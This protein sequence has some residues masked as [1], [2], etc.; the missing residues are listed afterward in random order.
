MEILLTV[1]P[2]LAKYA[3]KNP[4]KYQGI[5]GIYSDPVGHKLGSGGGTVNVLLEHFRRTGSGKNY[6]GIGDL[7]KNSAA[8][9]RQKATSNQQIFSTW[10]SSGKRIIIHSD[11][12]SRRLPAYGMMGKSFIPFPVFRWGRGQRIDQTLFD[13]QRPLLEKI[14]E[15]APE[16]LNTLVAVGDA[17]VWTDQLRENIPQADVVCIGIWAHPEV[18]VK[19]GVF[20][21]PRNKPA[22]LDY[23]LQKPSLETLQSLTEHF[24]CLLDAGIWLLSDRA[25][26]AL[27]ERCGWMRDA[28]Y[29]MQN[30]G[31]WIKAYDLYSEFGSLLGARGDGKSSV[32]IV[33]MEGAEFYHFGSNADLLKS[34]SSLQNWV[35]DQREI[36]HKKIKPSPDIFVQN[37]RTSIQLDNRH[38]SIW[39]E[40]SDIS[41]GWRLINHHII[42]GVPENSWNLALPAGI[43][44]DFVPIGKQQW[45]IRNYGF[46]DPFR[47]ETSDESTMWMNKPIK[48]WFAERGFTEKELI[49]VCEGDIYDCRLFPV[50][51]EKEI[52]EE[53]LQWMISG[54]RD[55]KQRWLRGKRLSAGEIIKQAN[56]ERLGMMRDGWVGVSLER[57]AKNAKQSI[58]YQLDLKRVAEEFS[59]RKLELP[60]EM[61]DNGLRMTDQGLMKGI[62]DLMFRSAYYGIKK[63][64]RA[65]KY[66]DEAFALLK[67]GML[68]K[69]K[70]NKLRPVMSVKKD[71]ILWG[72]SP[73]RLDLAGG[74]TDTPPYCILYGGSVVNMAVELNGQPPIQVYIRPTGQ[75]GFR[76]HSIDLGLSETVR[77]Y[78][79]IDRLSKVGSAFAIPKAALKLAGFHPQYSSAVYKSLEEQLRDFGG[80]LD[81]SLMVAVPKGSGLGTSSVLAGTILA[82]LSDFCKLGWD[83]HETAFRTLL[84]EQILTTGGGWQDQVGGLFEGVK[85]IESASG[86]VQKPRIRWV[87]EHLFTRPETSQLIMLYYTGITRIAKHI[88]TDIVQGMFL[89]SD[90]LLGILSEMK[91]HARDTYGAIQNH[92]WDGLTTA[93]AHSWELN[94]RLDPGT[95]PPE[96]AAIS[97]VIKDHMASCKLL[98]AGGG[99]YLIIF[100]KD[101]RS[102]NNIKVLLNDSPPNPR[103]RFVDW[104]LSDSGLEITKS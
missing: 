87:P 99:G 24:L 65:G 66:R 74:W 51:D 54:E 83:K 69:I 40:N 62:H 79:D 98:G 82:G 102:A 23:M 14:L 38:S 78:E 68:E 56:L 95:N 89:N 1:P 39:I 55:F 103:A 3:K 49:R 44:L 76:I 15:K 8:R 17:L 72:R 104:N 97:D 81:I 60:G 20:V 57:L 35:M 70:G 33:P 91:T 45:C 71:Q 6:E 86:L 18:A 5:S 92:D 64:K 7:L 12:Q 88:L 67:E 25:V 2:N 85:L 28:V 84:L 41:E 26:L 32:A 93:I 90:T 48:N 47:G 52:N 31:F 61:I 43:C 29:E 100:A 77:S 53:L 9:N 42:T 21:C 10:L 80:G 59:L 22:T 30:E 58:F 94:Q 50:L 63:D 36:W 34:T 4:E 16:G 101:Q 27:F 73:L 37:S 96:I 75:H 11:G 19:H 46:N 13:I